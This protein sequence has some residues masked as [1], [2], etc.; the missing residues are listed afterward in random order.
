[1]GTVEVPADRYWGAQTERSLHN[2]NIGRETFV[3]GRPMIKALG[4]LKKA[5]AQA[6]GELGELPEDIADLVVRAAD[7]GVG[8]AGSKHIGQS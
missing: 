4:T 3:W 8:A 2:F 6:N 1:M 5:A 7:E